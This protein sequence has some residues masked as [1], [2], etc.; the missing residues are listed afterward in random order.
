MILDLS[1]LSHIKT[2]IPAPT[3]SLMFRAVDEGTFIESAGGATANA[4]IGRFT[5][6]SDEVHDLAREIA[7]NEQAANPNVIFAELGQLSDPH[8]DNINRRKHSYNFEIP[9]NSISTLPPS[10]Q[11]QLSDLFL[12]VDGNNLILESISHKKV[13][14]PRLTSA[15]NYQHNNLSV[16]RLLCD[17]QYQ[18]IQGNYSFSLER[19]FPGMLSYPRV[20]YENTIL[21]P[22]TWHLSPTDIIEL[23]SITPNENLSWYY[24]LKKRLNLPAYLAL[25]KFDQQLVFNTDSKQDIHFLIECLRDSQ[26]PTLQEFF[27]P[28]DG[29]VE[30]E[31][32]ESLINQLVS[33]LYHNEEVYEG[34]L[35]QDNFPH[36]KVARNYILGSKWLYLKLYCNPPLSNEILLK[37]LMP[38]LKPFQLSGLKSWFF[39]RYWDSG[40]HIRLRLLINDADQARILTLLRNRLTATVNY[41]LIREYSADTYRRELERY[42]VDMIE[43]M[44]DFFYVSSELILRYINA[45]VKESFPYKYHSLAFVS[46]QQMISICLPELNDQISFLQQMVNAFYVEFS[47]DKNLKVDL[48][49]KYRE[50]KS[51]IKKD[52]INPGYYGKIRL[53]K[54]EAKFLQVTST[55]QQKMNKFEVKR[56]LQLLADMIHMHLNR[57]FIDRQRHQELV[58]YYCLYKYQLSIR[59]MR[60]SA[61]NFPS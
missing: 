23:K 52:L 17:L 61:S 24:S 51:E 7:I 60:R 20:T 43:Q 44:E 22:A 57:L 38:L 9:I 14:I 13:I 19:Y 15:F 1:N 16:F 11:L 2:L 53:K 21:F 31:D 25:T 58:T 54:Y 36:K 29:I 8:T 6:W 56:Q 27:T 41:H 10:Q 33:F 45:S 47:T 5:S 55:T 32:G 48:D 18:G 39:I 28:K 50:L 42:G 35:K 26:N 37:K 3:I 49:L 12:S 46:V 34:N 40:Y 59:A 30:T 4:I